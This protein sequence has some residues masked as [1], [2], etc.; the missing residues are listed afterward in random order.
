MFEEEKYKSFGT[1][2]STETK[3]FEQPTVSGAEISSEDDYSVAPNYQAETNYSSLNS[4]NVETEEAQQVNYFNAPII[5]KKQVKQETVTLTKQ[6]QVIRLSGRLKIVCA[7]FLTIMISLLTLICY[8]FVSANRINASLEAKQ[9]KVAEL[10]LSINALS[11]QYNMLTDDEYL[12][13][14]A[15]ELGYVAAD[16]SNTVV[17]KLDEMYVKEEPEEIPSNWF[18]DVCD[19]FAKIF[20]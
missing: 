20:G 1:T 18:N 4:E 6:K 7:M 5:T 3:K 17:I 9:A 10:E 11:E 15:E 8:N 13:E 14:A 2:T 19:F 16:D 12:T